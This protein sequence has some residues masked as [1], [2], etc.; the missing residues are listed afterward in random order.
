MRNFAQS[1]ASFM[2]QRSLL[3][4]FMENVYRVPQEITSQTAILKLSKSRS[5]IVKPT[6]ADP[7]RA[8]LYIHGGAMC[9]SLWKFYLPFVYKLAN[10]TNSTV[11]MP[12]YRLAPEFPFPCGLDDCLETFD[13]LVSS[14]SFDDIVIVGDSAGGNLAMNLAKVNSDRIRGV[15]LLSPWLDLTHTST[16]FR[17]NTADEFVY[18]ESANKAAWLYVMGDQDWT[19]GANSPQLSHEFHER[20]RDPLVSPVFADLENLSS[21]PFL[22]QASR[23]ER[24]IGD[25]VHLFRRLG[26]NLT[27]EDIL[28]DRNSVLTCESGL[29]RLS[30]WADQ[31]H[32]WQI[33]RPK[34]DTGKAAFSEIVA[35]CRK[36]FQA[37]AVN[38]H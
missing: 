2:R 31:P 28:S 22:I 33:T 27:D 30:L 6:L 20:V 26:G 3:N 8:L 19:F 7:K 34:S 35:F 5:F 11:F 17:T 36:R 13:S 37:P 29:H 10:D 21:V 38:L 1:R 18:P 25:S 23:S 24:L 16:F 4:G 32:V 9:L 14:R 15:C 12:D